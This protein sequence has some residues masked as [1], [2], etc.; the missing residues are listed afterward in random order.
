MA[1]SGIFSIAGSALSAESIRLNTTASNLANAE[2]VGQTEQSAYHAKHPL[3]TAN[4]SDNL[5]AGFLKQ[6]ETG[7]SVAAIVEDN[8]PLQKRFEPNH[9]LANEDGYVYVPN[10][11]AMNEMA[12]FISGSRAYQ[13]NVQV[14]K[15]TKQMQQAA[16]SLGDI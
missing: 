15:A 8:T 14:I 3:F 1:L 6:A 12:D 10:V 2:S 16:L 4:K 9:P 11:N 5:F 7:V 13:S